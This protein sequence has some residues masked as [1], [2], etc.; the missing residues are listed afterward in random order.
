MRKAFIYLIIFFF[1]FIPIAY[2]GF[3]YFSVLK[4]KSFLVKVV[5]NF[6]DKEPEISYEIR[7]FPSHLVFRIKNLEISG[8]Q[9]VI[10]PGDLLVK[11]R[12]LDRSVYIY[13][14]NNQIEATINNN[15]IKCSTN[16]KNFFT[17][18]LNRL[19]FLLRFDKAINYVNAI[20]YE[21]Y[22]LKC[23]I[24]PDHGIKKSI[25]TEVDNNA[26]HVRFD[27]RKE[28]NG[29]LKLGTDL[30]MYRFKDMV[31]PKSFLNV[32][33]KFGSEFIGD[34]SASK[35]NLN[36]EKFLIRNDSFSFTANGKIQDYNL[37]TL[38][39]KNQ[40]NVDISNYKELVS[41][42]IDN[43]SNARAL[44]E[45]IF[46]LSEKKINGDIQ[47]TIRYDDDFGSSFIGSLPAADFI[48]KLNEITQNRDKG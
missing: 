48:E 28:A 34:I 29:N 35:L 6:T 11:N 2:G 46:S 16:E 7:G 37:V 31:S 9:L 21:D 39:F 12:L 36:L 24:I 23:D 44:Q 20:E 19:P 25:V 3:W 47:F 1:L 8:G 4:A 45:L 18:E 26:N 30:Y 33:V 32:D 5:S 13:T 15:N 14:P 38:A 27:F 22:G 43:D 17:V 10:L 42:M 41:R 40:I